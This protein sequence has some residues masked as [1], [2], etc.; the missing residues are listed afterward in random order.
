MGS[1][2]ERPDEPARN[3][4]VPDDTSG[5]LQGHPNSYLRPLRP[6]SECF[7]CEVDSQGCFFGAE[8]ME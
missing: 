2:H 5:T 6:V 3:A 1:G 4:D 7:L 8:C